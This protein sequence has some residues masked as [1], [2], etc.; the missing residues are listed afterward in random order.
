M[1]V[2]AGEHDVALSTVKPDIIE[3]EFTK[4][5]LI[6]IKDHKMGM[7]WPVVYIIL[8]KKEVYVGE[9]N[10]A[11]RRMKQHL[12]DPRRKDMDL[13][14][15]VFDHTLNKSVILDMEQSLI[16][17]FAAYN[18]FKLQNENGGQSEKH[19]YYQ[20]FYYQTRVEEVWDWFKGNNYVDKTYWSLRNTNLYKYSPYIA[21]NSNQSDVCNAILSG[22]FPED[23]SKKSGMVVVRGV[24]GTGKTIV[25]IHMISKLLRVNEINSEPIPFSDEM[26]D[27]VRIENNILH[28]IRNLGRKLK[29][30][31]VQP[32]TSI[33]NTMIQVFKES[34]LKGCEVIGPH[35]VVG[36]NYDIVFVDEAH[37]L[38]DGSNLGQQTGSYREKCEKIGITDIKNS[39]ALDLIIKSCP[40]CVIFYDSEQSIRSNDMT[41]E[42]FRNAV[43]DVY[44]NYTLTTEMRCLGGMAYMEY[45]SRIFS[46]TQDKKEAME[47]GFEVLLFDDVSVMT[48]RII[49]LNK[50]VGLCR[51]VA[52]YA[53]KWVT[54]GK[55]QKEIINSDLFD[56]DIDGHRYF[57][58]TESKKGW[59]SREDSVNEIG[60]VHTTQGFDLNY[61]G[62]IIG[63]DLR[64]ENGN[65]IADPRGSH[66]SKIKNVKDLGEA[67][68]YIVNS[69]KVLMSRGVKGCFIYVC[70]PGLRA[71]MKQFF[72]TYNPNSE[73]EIAD[74]TD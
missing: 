36:E 43:G 27:D 37:R 28:Y 20:R 69:Y 15:V 72:D 10:S 14:F 67:R 22:F 54:K 5:G 42:H 30:A 7:N 33:R 73:K 47:S 13:F 4:D 23:M 39:S 61:V 63:N 17:L 40:R 70:N 51:N 64:F 46:R 57:W 8:G 41:E 49:S 53:W 3:F 35:G 2:E 32:M 6:E 16:H 65:I 71:Y 31:F 52:G 66:D 19:E 50:D 60:C 59:I 44:D 24:A 1:D 62:V 21:L 11:Y 55:T 29:I 56:I 12:D 34:G 74:K 45:I 25:A 26:N 68:K 58:N 48:D 9:T 18:R 38:I